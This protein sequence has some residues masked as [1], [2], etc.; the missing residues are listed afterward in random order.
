MTD[1]Q[2]DPGVQAQ[3]F[4]VCKAQGL[5][6]AGLL[7][8]QEQGPPD[9]ISLVLLRAVQLNLHHEAWGSMHT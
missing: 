2:V 9:G 1:P 4:P 3:A 5:Q 6:Q 7:A 8:V